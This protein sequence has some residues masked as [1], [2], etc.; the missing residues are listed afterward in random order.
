M[1]QKLRM[2]STLLPSSNRRAPRAAFTLIEL[3][4]VIAI[5][6]I[7][8]AM[9]LP[10]M[11]KAKSR[12]QALSCINNLRQLGAADAIYASDLANHFAPNPAKDGV[13]P[14]ESAQNA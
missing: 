9:L 7:L 2:Q 11:P 12:A 13:P 8:A 1:H 14:G 10:A 4:V 5:N 3:L 6:A